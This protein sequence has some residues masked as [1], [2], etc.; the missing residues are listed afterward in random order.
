M[1]CHF[2]NFLITKT[3][4]EGNLENLDKQQE[5]NKNHKGSHLPEIIIVDFQ[6]YPF[7]LNLFPMCIFL[8]EKYPVVFR[9]LIFFFNLLHYGSIYS[10]V[11]IKY[12][13][14]T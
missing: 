13:V 11:T 14:I 8:N 10:A 9:F 1:I 5:E 4:V 7:Y 6:L 12:H 3:F 2:Y